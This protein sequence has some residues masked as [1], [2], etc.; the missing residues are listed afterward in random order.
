MPHRDA[1]DKAGS[2][3][4]YRLKLDE[5]L[6]DLIGKLVIDWGLGMRSWIQRV[7]K[8][9]KPM[10]VAAKLGTS[11]ARPGGRAAREPIAAWGAILEFLR[12]GLDSLN[13]RDRISC[14]VWS[15]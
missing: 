7:D 8:Q 13:E 10:S 2:C 9:D 4:V 15:Q 5:R 11:S 1:V 6:G 14:C 3:D 12:T